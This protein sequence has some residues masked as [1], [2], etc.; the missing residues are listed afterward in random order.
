MK[1]NWRTRN[2][3]PTEMGLTTF[4]LLTGATYGAYQLGRLGELALPANSTLALY[5][6]KMAN[7]SRILFPCL[8][9]PLG[10]F[11][12]AAHFKGFKE[13]PKK[14]DGLPALA[15]WGLSTGLAPLLP[16]PFSSWLNRIAS[17]SMALNCLW[18][19]ASLGK[20]D[21]RIQASALFFS[22]AHLAAT[23]LLSTVPGSQWIEPLSALTALGLTFRQ[24]ARAESTP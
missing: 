12:C 10:L 18:W 7:L 6:T 23:G 11:S 1:C 21:R 5:S 4:Y 14:I 17:G 20:I 24:P 13:A 3:T 15:V 2:A 16:L 19:T 22:A 9:A 8:A